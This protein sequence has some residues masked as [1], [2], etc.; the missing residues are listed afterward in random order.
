ME[1]TLIEFDPARDIPWTA[2]LQGI[3]STESNAKKLSIPLLRLM[4]LR[5]LLEAPSLR[6]KKSDGAAE[7]KQCFATQLL[8]ICLVDQ[9]TI[10]AGSPVHRA[11][12]IPRRLC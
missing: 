1:S 8:R 12:L 10:I 5:F 11:D 4:H 7:L 9:H 2:L 6:T 3:L